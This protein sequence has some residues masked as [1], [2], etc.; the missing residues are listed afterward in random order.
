M[1]YSLI[2]C[3]IVWVLGYSLGT[4][5]V[6]G[7]CWAIWVRLSLG[8]LKC[9]LHLNH[10]HPF[11]NELCLFILL[12]Y[13]IMIFAMFVCKLGVFRIGMLDWV[14]RQNI[15]IRGPGCW[16]QQY[17][18]GIGF[19]AATVLCWIELC[20]RPKMIWILVFNLWYYL[21]LWILL[22]CSWISFYP[23]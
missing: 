20:A 15:I 22:C 8:I 16:L 11:L 12:W 5:N 14:S 7:S 13:Y 21:P 6:M 4:S 23:L 1:P 3:C 9:L 17:G 18:H 19:L 2:L 10:V